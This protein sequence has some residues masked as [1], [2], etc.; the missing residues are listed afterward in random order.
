M[1]T[2][3]NKHNMPSE[4]ATTI[5]CGRGSALGNPFAMG[6][7]ASRNAVCDQ[8]EGWFKKR[9]NTDFQPFHDQLRKI[10]K[11]HREGDVYLQCFCTPLRCHCE[12][13]KD[14]IESQED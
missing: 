2:I 5:Y 7:A 4:P 1:I 10:L 9:L 3:V 14:Y 13:I 11:A 12:T 8:Y 6:S